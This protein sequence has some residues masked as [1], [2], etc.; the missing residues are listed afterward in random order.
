[1]VKCKGCNSRLRWDWSQDTYII[2][3]DSNPQTSI[4]KDDDKYHY[5]TCTCGRPLGKQDKLG[6]FEDVAWLSEV[7]WED[8]A[9]IGCVG[10]ISQS[11]QL[12]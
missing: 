7:N 2:G 4:E 6:E 3:N 8:G 12:N 10:L 11:K 5:Y 9:N 1:M